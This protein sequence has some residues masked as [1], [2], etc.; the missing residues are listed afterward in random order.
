MSKQKWCPGN[1]EE[2]GAKSPRHREHQSTPNVSLPPIGDNMCTNVLYDGRAQRVLG[3][4]KA[5][6]GV[7]F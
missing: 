4:N 6:Q 2:I 3:N 1:W 5:R 7:K